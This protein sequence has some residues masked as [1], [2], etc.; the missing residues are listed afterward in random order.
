MSNI[1]I[2][3]LDKTKIDLLKCISEITIEKL[4]LGKKSQ[5]YRFEREGE[6]WITYCLNNTDEFSDEESEYFFKTINDEALMIIIEANEEWN[7]SVRKA[8]RINLS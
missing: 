1:M 3:E 8:L 4:N 7:A 6:Y 5:Y 2:S